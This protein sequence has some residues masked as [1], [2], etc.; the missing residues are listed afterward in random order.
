MMSNNLWCMLLIKLKILI[1]IYLWINFKP[2]I[3]LQKKQKSRPQNSEGGIAYVVNT[4][5][6]KGQSGFFYIVLS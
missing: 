1:P 2:R 6:I 4:S 5:T 3:L